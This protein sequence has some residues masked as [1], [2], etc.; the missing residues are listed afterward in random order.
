MLLNLGALGRNLDVLAKPA[1][2]YPTM[3]GSQYPWRLSVAGTK[4]AGM[5]KLAAIMS[6]TTLPGR[7]DELRR[8]WQEHLQAR[9][10]QSAVQE[11]YLVVE[12]ADDADTLHF[13]E[14]YADG[15]QM[16]ANAEAPWFGAY[17][18]AVKP[19]LAGPPRVATGRPVWAKGYPV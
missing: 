10:E 17:L 6:I 19:L 14:V 15:A 8:L 5:S 13:V 1:P 12:D 11:F 7:R 4:G 16:V 2:P 9:V 3:D 18:A